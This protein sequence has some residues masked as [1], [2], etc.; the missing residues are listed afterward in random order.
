M[1][2]AIEPT[3]LAARA[4]WLDALVAVDGRSAA[5]ASAY[6]RDTRQFLLALS[7]HLGERVGLTRLSSLRPQ[8]VRAFLAARRRDGVSA[9]SLARSLAAVRTFMAA[10]EREHGVNAAPVRAVRAARMSPTLPRPVAMAAAAKLLTPDGKDWVSLR[11]SAVM[12]LLYGAGLRIAEALSLS[13]T[14]IVQGSRFVTVV[15][16]GGKA[17]SVPMLPIVVEAV[18]RYRATAPFDLTGGP[19]FLGEKGGRLSARVVQ[20]AMAQARAAL[21]L[22]DSATPHALRHAFATHILKNGGDLRAIQALLGHARLSTTQIYTA[23][24][25]SQLAHTVKECHP[26]A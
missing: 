18:E 11:D 12:T 14:D 5:T 22:P 16:K 6:E 21:G 3:L 7:E 9:R 24:D 23:V 13:A 26:R 17:R 10:M 8:D 19:L 1:Q 4:A 20:R 25:A 2:H 15:G